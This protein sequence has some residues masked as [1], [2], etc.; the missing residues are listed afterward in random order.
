MY[1]V[2]CRVL[3]PSLISRYFLLFLVPLVGNSVHQFL[4]GFGVGE[5]VV[6]LKFH[7]FVE[8]KHVGDA[9]GEVE[10]D[11]VLFGDVF[12]VFDDAAET[13]AVGGND[14]V[15]A[16]FGFREN[17]LFPVG[18]D[19]VDGI[20]KGFGMRLGLRVV[21]VLVADVFGRVALVV[22]GQTFGA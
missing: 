1:E 12:Q 19:A 2:Q 13:V 4:E 17:H 16:L 5:E 14:D 8:F 18:D 21:D 20:H 11:D 7:V 9:G 10:V 6:L 15:A 3:Y 22:I